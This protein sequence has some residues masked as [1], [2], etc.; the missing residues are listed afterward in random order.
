MFTGIVQE[1]GSVEDCKRGAGGMRLKVHAPASSRELGID[2]SIAVNGACLTVVQKSEPSFELEAV[3]ETLSKTTLGFFAIGD[4][5]NLELPMRVSDRLDGHLVLGHVDTVGEI[6]DV[7]IL[8]SSRLFAVRIPPEFM[9]Y[10]VRSGSIAIDG[11]SLT[12]ARISGSTI[13]VS[14]IPHTLEN[15]IFQYYNV[16]DRVNL[17]FDVV[18]KYVERMMR[19][20]GGELSEQRVLSEKY[21]RELGF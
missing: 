16:S 17:E 20:A 1:V 11:V 8:G 2:R 3:E 10:C 18:G 15:T 9:H 5:V 19:P 12:I 14:I 6:M 7:E 21:L 4:Q 13:G